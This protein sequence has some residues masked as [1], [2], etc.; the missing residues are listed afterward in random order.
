MIKLLRHI[1]E[2]GR[3]RGRFFA[4]FPA[5]LCLLSA[6][7][8]AET[9]PPGTAIINRAAVTYSDASGTSLSLESNTVSVSMLSSL[10]LLHLEKGA[11]PDPVV[12]GSTVTY[13]IRMENRGI[14]RL[15]NIVL[16]DPLPDS[17][18]FV[19][20][21][22]EG[23]PSAD[24]REV[25]WNIGDLEVEEELSVTLVVR[26]A[27][28][29][30]QGR[31]IENTAT[32]VSLETGT[33]TA[34]AFVNINARTPGEVAF[35]DDKWAPTY[36]YM[37]GDTVNVQVRDLDQNLDPAVAETVT[38]VLENSTTGD[39]ETLVLTETG[40]DTGIFRAG[41][42]STLS[43][44]S[45][46][47]GVLTVAIDSSVYALYVDPMDAEPVS[48]AAAFFEPSGIMFDSVTG[49][50]IE[51]AVVSLRNWNNVTD[52]C[53]T[54]TWPALAPG[55]KNPSSPTGPD[56]RYAF[57]IAPPGDYCLIVNPPSGYEYPSGV[58]DSDL[59]TGFRINSMSRGGRFSITPGDLPVFGDIP[60]DP[61]SGWLTVKKT[62]NKT[63][64]A[65]GDMIIYT[66]ILENRGPS[67]VT[68]ITITDI[69]PH[70]ITHI[71]GSSRL[72]SKT[73]DDPIP[74]GDR[75]FTWQAPDLDPDGSLNVSYRAVAGPDSQSGNGIN[76]AFASGMSVGKPIL[77]SRVSF[78]VKVTGGVFTNKGT[79]IGRVFI[80]PDEGG[81]GN[82]D[83]GV[84]GIVLYLED[85]ARVITDKNGKYSIAGVSPGTHVLRIDETSIPEGLLPKAGSNRF[86]GSL[87]SQFIDM[88]YGGLF[89]A[90]FPMKNKG[91]EKKYNEPRYESGA[92][93]TGTVVSDKITIPVKGSEETGAALI[94]GIE[95]KEVTT[96]TD[97]TGQVPATGNVTELPSEEQILTMKPDLDFLMPADGTV[98]GH[99]TIRV[100]VKTP[101]DTSLTL[102]VNGG[103]VADNRIG[104]RI[105]NEQ[106]RVAI[107]EFIGIRLDR[108]ETNLLKAEIR[109]SFGIAR[110]EK[111]IRVETIGRPERINIMPDQ[112]E[113][114][115][116]GESQTGITVSLT[117]K[118]ERVA[119]FVTSVTAEI[120]AGRILEMDADPNTGGHQILCRNGIAF[121]T[122]IAPREAG[123]AKIHV[124]VDGLSDSAEIYFF[125]HLRQMLMVGLGEV[126]IGH[127]RSSGDISFLKE[128]SFFDDGTYIDG[129][130]AFFLKGNIYK[131]FLLTA[132]YDSGKE[133]TNELFRESDTHLDTEDKY[134]VYGDESETEYEAV[135]RENLYVKVEKGKSSLLYGDFRTDLTGTRLSAYTRSLNGLKLDVNNERF[136]LRSIGSYTDQSQVVDTIPGK[137]I[138]GPYYLDSSRIIEGSERVTLEV[139][140]RLQPDRV[141]SRELTSRGTEYDIDYSMGIIL[142]K[143][144]VPSH[145]AYGNPV[146]IIVHYES[147]DGGEKYFIYGGRG[148]YKFSERLEAGVTGI[149][150]ENGISN[151]RLFGGDMT[152]NLPGETILRAE[153]AS[154]RG[155]FDN[156]GAFAPETGDG[157]SFDIRSKP[158]ESLELT[159]YYQRL[160]EFYSNFSAADAIR[161]TR[162][163]GLDAVYEFSPDLTIRTGYLNEKDSIND[164]LNRTAFIIANKRYEKTKINA[165]LSYETSYNV[166]EIPAQTPLR[167]GGLLNGIPLI[168]EY[169]TPESATFLKL[170]LE[171]EIMPD[172][173]L[174]ISHSHDVGGDDL[175]ISQG[176]LN[177]QVNKN[178]RVYI[179]EEY[180]RY[181]EGTQARTLFGMESQITSNTN[182]YQKYS[183]ADGASGKR[184][185][186]IMGLNN[187]FQIMNG[188]TANLAAEYL[189]TLRGRENVNEPDAYA[190][191]AG[192]EYLTREDLKITGRAEHR[193]EI[194]ENGNDSY[195]AEIAMA[196]KI[197]SDYTLML[198]ER[199]FVEKRGNE[200][201]DSTSRL[202][203]GIAYRPRKND[204]FNAL[205]RIEYKH[206][207]RTSTQP[208]YLKE[209]FI[210]SLEG[211]YQL[212]PRLQ[213]TGKYAGKLE[214][215]DVFSSYTDL[216]AF[217]ILYD[218]TD[219]FDI[220]AEYR[221]LNSRK[222]NTSQHGGSIEIG[223]RLM[224]Q[225]WLSLG[226]SFDSFDPDLA[227]DP[228]RGKSPYLKLRFKF[229]ENTFK[230]LK[231]Q[232]LLKKD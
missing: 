14:S 209:S 189:S 25:V 206:E 159:G 126:V 224:D 146:Y 168:N 65:I 11:Y 162:K 204:S 161:G 7:V 8:M 171:R 130:G 198:R 98:T 217:R 15:T 196:H 154:T 213:L 12:A 232:S 190:A 101:A 132:A 153:Y 118:N 49:D 70:G 199:Y 76:T 107:Y 195:L 219:R 150:E 34:G 113:S 197:N 100:I 207:K 140:D 89:R 57:P 16:T 17:T 27:G 163:W 125:P 61:P 193:H 36:G 214:K 182:V 39:A 2:T 84:P 177:Y 88:A 29:L 31:R 18:V 129:R 187:K 24:E 93:H 56:G 179:R 59:P 92:S 227:G 52:S 120:T 221:L 156:G 183:L 4:F 135:S 64:A 228:Y 141:M 38:V 123:E 81:S 44:T 69:M 99:D 151:Y 127:G 191:A 166:A 222:I 158:V 181:Q 131:D 134:P 169:E 3:F 104:T 33:Q 122:V 45:N 226:Y 211:N 10:P 142:F 139:R 75:T 32:A 229:D 185:Q 83:E 200:G 48:R 157:W 40:P 152:L 208:S 230:D 73:F 94:H 137:G 108:G 55:Q 20:A 71:S 26:T 46:E 47:N 112:K 149:V 72:D 74:S 186:Q 212:N 106:N 50:P 80:E 23:A 215:E 95:T 21:D 96:V 121:F 172:L 79:I 53:D 133:K 54:S 155:L 6:G 103:K 9:A 1:A 201:E 42:A 203:A 22:R 5:L 109:D 102:T 63:H 180:A 86:M 97:V 231:K 82:R 148:S 184:N 145:D 66:L 85:G 117:D 30:T 116:D 91:Y 90:D 220:G 51:G 205:G 164:S 170:G 225:I 78:R 119:P 43:S 175:S 194:K 87:T 174:S 67:P 124:E 58:S 60:L 105:L 138:S 35:F 28:D 147:S 115:A 136:H 77:S 68:G 167:Q 223:Y 143:T 19:S 178:N 37:S 210:L 165:G 41:I 218:L 173:S 192:L 216:V 160:S 110:E 13:T 128:N 62:A 114:V 188:V 202:I 176:S 144:P 111:Q